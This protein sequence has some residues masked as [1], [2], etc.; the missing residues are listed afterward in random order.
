[1]KEF[2]KAGESNRIIYIEFQYYQIGLDEEWLSKM[3][4]MIGDA[5]VV[6]REILL[7]RL[8]GS[9]LSPYPQEDIEY[10]V[11]NMHK[12]IDVL[13]VKDYYQFMIYEE[14]DPSIP[15]IVGVDCSTGTNK[16]NNAITG[17]NPYTTRPTFEF[18]C[19]YVGETL[20][21]QII[22]ELV[23]RHVPKAIVCVERNSVGDGIIDHLLQS[24]IASRLYYD[25]A[26]DLTEENK[27]EYE[28]IE[29][30]LKKQAAQ[31][32][33]YGV[34]TEGNSREAMFA[35]LARRISENK[36]DFVAE[37]VITDISRLVRASSGKI[38]AGPGFH[39]DSVMS[40]LIAMY[41]LYHGNNLQIFGYYPGEREEKPRNQGIHERTESELN[42]VLPADIA[43]AI[44]EEKEAMKALDYEA[45][46]RN[47]IEKS[48]AETSRLVNSS[49]NFTPEGLD[50]NNK[51]T[52]FE[53]EISDYDMGFFDD[54][55]G[56]G[57]SSD[58]GGSFPW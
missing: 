25:R 46:L 50:S 8:H 29:S 28:T 39:D 17:I 14:L 1:M 5:L 49:L 33:F 26:K 48:Q 44:M 42:K 58:S 23:T 21:E 7:Q 9:S 20:Y 13:F 22:I 10:I 27:K 57:G 36:D 54:L 40:Y 38:L 37:N 56:L 16:D 18:A 2:A 15:Y 55:N 41:V 24:R 30:M 32:S 53:D 51:Y 47:A 11:E 31:K 6:R 52:T 35:I 3:S 43:Q 45:I 34:Y 12:P 19:S 4:N